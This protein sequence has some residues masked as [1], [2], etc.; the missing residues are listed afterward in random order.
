[1]EI[2]ELIKH[3]ENLDRD[4]LY[5]LREL[6]ALYPY[7][8]T[9][10]ILMLKNLY[11]LH[12]PSF[13]EELRRAA[14]YITDRKVLFQMI[15]AGHYQLRTLRKENDDT[16]TRAS[17]TIQERDVVPFHSLTASLTHCQ[18]KQN[19]KTGRSGNQH[20]SMLLSTM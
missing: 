5:E 7:F 10:R 19:R 16:N 11:L 17:K 12:D 3:P 18:R 9:A 4:T 2:V 15:E 1:M 6:L 14:I 13:D 20:P 8:Q